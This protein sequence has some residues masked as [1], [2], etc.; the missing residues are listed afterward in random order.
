MN[1]DNSVL[2]PVGS[3]TY[4]GTQIELPE[5]NPSS[6][7]ADEIGAVMIDADKYVD[8]LET[9]T[10]AQVAEVESTEPLRAAGT[11][12]WF[13]LADGE[14]ITRV[15][16][17]AM[18]W[19]DGLQLHT[20][21]RSSPWY[22]GTGGTLHALQAADG[23]RV[24]SFFGMRGDSHV[25]TLGVRCLPTSSLSLPSRSIEANGTSNAV[26]SF[27]PAGKALE[28]GP[29]IPFSM[30]LPVIGAVV[31]R[32]GRFVES[33]QVLSPEEAA[34]NARDPRIYRSNEHVF[35][36]CLGEKLIKLE[37]YSGHW[38]DCVRFTTTQRVG[39]WFGGGR[40]PNNAAM[41]SPENHHICGFHG[42]HGKQYVGSVGA[43]YC[44]D[45]RATHPQMELDQDA[46]Q[47]KPRL[48]W[49]MRTVPVSNQIAD[50]PLGPPL[51]VL[52]AV[53]RGSVTSVQSFDSLK[54]FD[55][56]VNQ[57]HSTLLSSGEPYQ[58]HCIPLESGE[59]LVQ[60]DV[61]FR[62]AS[63]NDPYQA[64]DGVCFHTTTRCSSWFGAYR[65]SNLRFFMAPAGTGIIQLEGTYTQ[66]ILTNL[67]GVVGISAVHSPQFTP[68]ARVLS[69]DGAY[70]VRLE[71]A[72]P[73]F[74]IE[75]VL[76]VKK[77]NG[78]NHDEHAWTW[79]QPGMPYPRVWRVPYKM[80]EDRIQGADS[81]STLFEEYLVGAINSGGA[82]TKTA[83]P[84]L[85]R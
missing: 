68:D 2:G 17:R 39:P 54:M 78:D 23:W 49:V 74:G 62:A 72:S 10:R 58:V 52:V 80:L 45:G 25:G 77:N 84:V 19:I 9:R 1:W 63:A 61:S 34:S 38:V 12:H 32:C 13:V 66:S 33:I 7:V 57:L 44:A 73:E 81:K 82:Y 76:L 28:D 20:N 47:A 64:I 35:E 50:H 27:P 59:K 40:G 51:G 29:N 75:N 42:I 22:G 30:T 36:L 67:T 53:Q 43:L 18:A 69:D 65:E 41:E 21:L 83:A 48:F 71:A 79:N 16:V 8:H 6:S 15:D 70:D 85:R 55:E 3:G 56:Q 14:Y 46:A 24:S 11:K 4:N 37:V 31:V 60:I 5:N 26:L